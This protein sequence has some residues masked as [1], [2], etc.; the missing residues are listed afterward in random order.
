MSWDGSFLL[1]LQIHASPFTSYSSVPEADSWM[2]LLDSVTLWLLLSSAN[3][4]CQ[5]HLGKG[6][7]VVS[8]YCLPSSLPA[9][10]YWV[11]YC[12]LTKIPLSALVW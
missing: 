7:R 8:V 5:W 4:R 11:D 6:R 3:G 9:L 2:F 1:P 12:P 10:L